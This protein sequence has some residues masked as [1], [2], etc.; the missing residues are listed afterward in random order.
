MLKMFKSRFLPVL[1]VIAAL[2]S[3]CD[4]PVLDISEPSHHE[5]TSARRALDSVSIPPP[6]RIPASEMQK[7]IERV[8]GPIRKAA[9]EVCRELTLPDVRCQNVLASDLQ[10][11]AT[12]QDMNAYA[13][14]HNN[15]GFTGGMIHYSGSDEELAAVYAHELAHVMYGH[16]DKK[17]NNMLMGMIIG[18]GIGLAAAYNADPYYDDRITYD[19]MNTGA[20]IGSVAYSPEMEIE[21]DRTAIYILEKAGYSPDSMRDVIVRLHR[22]QDGAIGG[23]PNGVG[24]LQTHPSNDRR[25]AHILSSIDDVKSGVPLRLE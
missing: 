12:D 17:I 11:M 5:K 1:L 21:S 16:V 4:A 20:A 6:R 9:F 25:I 24:F 13:D 22:H 23:H 3:G 8:E 7:T 19:L 15:V 10:V 14:Y 2:V 18:G